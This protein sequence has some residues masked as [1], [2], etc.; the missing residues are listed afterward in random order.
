MIDW[1]A[2]KQDFL[3][4]FDGHRE[5]TWNC[6]VPVSGGK[7]STSQVLKILELG[8]RPLAVTSKTCDLSDIG[9]RNLNTLRNLGV[10]SIEVAPDPVVRR[11]LNRL[12][13]EQVGDISWP[14]HVGIFTIPV[15]IAI[16]FG[17]PNII[18]GENSQNEYGGPDSAA[19]SMVLD[20]R[21]LDEY[22][23]LLGMRPSDAV[24]LL[25]LDNRAMHLYQ[26]PDALDLE[27]VGVRGIFLGQYFPWSGL[28][29]AITAQAVGFETFGRMVEGSVVD[30]ENLDN[31]QT[32][33]HDYFK[34]LKF[35]FGRATD[36]ASSLIR[37]GLMSRQF[38]LEIVLERDGMFPWSYLGKPLGQ[39]L[40]ELDLSLERFFQ[41]CDQFTNTSL[42]QKN[43][44]GSLARRKDGSP[45]TK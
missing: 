29:N 30:Y 33:I 23:G 13:L 25:D 5:H 9:A 4:L 37:R 6:V 15:N 22:G 35:G 38:A 18:W 17:I 45:K 14:E 43:L 10:D 7:D 36:I 34:Y 42:F 31:I 20:Q 28:G 8:L 3:Q 39:T 2:K 44:D 41:I 40:E 16:K 21:W 12:G 32:G 24:D 27:R 19:S 1:E 11:R 26:Y